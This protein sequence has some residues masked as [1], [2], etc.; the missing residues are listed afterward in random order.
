M[1]A[2]R[3][4]NAGEELV[5]VLLVLTRNQRVGVRSVQ[6]GHA[7]SPVVVERS[8]LTIWQVQS[9]QPHIPEGYTLAHTTDTHFPESMPSTVSNK[10]SRSDP[11]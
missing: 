6:A 7:I 8:I 11:A 5:F 2:D 3:N 9:G 10:H 1:I 4:V